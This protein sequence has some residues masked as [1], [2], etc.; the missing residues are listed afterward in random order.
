MQNMCILT[1]AFAQGQK[2]PKRNKPVSGPPT[3]ARMVPVIL[4]YK[5]YF[6]FNFQRGI[7]T[8]FL[9]MQSNFDCVTLSRGSW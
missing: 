5:N 7:T 2:H 3:A 4:K 8:K 6:L 9:N 1:L